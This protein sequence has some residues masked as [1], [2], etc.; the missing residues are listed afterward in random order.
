M[1]EPGAKVEQEAEPVPKGEEFKINDPDGGKS[2][3]GELMD[4]D[5]FHTMFQAMVAAPNGVL[6]LKKVEPL[7]SLETAGNGPACRKASDALYDTCRD[8]PWL[9][10]MLDPDQVWLQRS[11]PVG[12]FVFGTFKAVRMELAER[13]KN[14]ASDPKQQ[15]TSESDKSPSPA[16]DADPQVVEEEGP[17]VDQG[18]TEL[19][20]GG[21]TK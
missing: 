6:M 3:G 13:A 17:G 20:V 10:F 2:S 16:P 21:G 8:V 7:K 18:V 5:E 11:L 14:S 19:K 12:V 9:K 15:K 1:P 4:R